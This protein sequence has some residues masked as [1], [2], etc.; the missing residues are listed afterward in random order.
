[1]LE[2]QLLKLFCV[3]LY[4]KVKNVFGYKKPIW[5]AL[6]AQVMKIRKNIKMLCFILKKCV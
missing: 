1:M 4:S 6:D 2:K 5:A 3:C